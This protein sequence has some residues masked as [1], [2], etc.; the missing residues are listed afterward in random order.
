MKRERQPSYQQVDSDMLVCLCFVMAYTL[1]NITAED[2][3][4]WECRGYKKSPTLFVEQSPM[5]E[6]YGFTI[7]IV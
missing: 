2:S 4:L 1:Y 3:I 7:I 5:P 6:R